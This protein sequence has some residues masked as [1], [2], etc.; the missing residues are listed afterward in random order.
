M[1]NF[2]HPFQDKTGVGYFTEDFPYTNKLLSETNNSGTNR[3]TYNYNSSITLST[4]SL[5]INEKTISVY[6]NPARDI[7]TIQSKSNQKIDRVIVTDLS[8]KKVLEQNNSNQLNLHN[9]AKGM[10]LLQAFS[11]ND[12]FQTKFIKE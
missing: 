8:G 5:L 7:L 10:Y 1:S 6:P 4:E 3:T 9:L 2:V 12:A 11:E